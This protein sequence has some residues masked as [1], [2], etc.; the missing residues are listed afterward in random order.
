[1]KIRAAR[2]TVRPEPQALEDRWVPSTLTVLNNLDS[3]PGSLR[4]ENT[5]AHPDDTIIFAPSL[6]RQTV[7]PDRVHTSNTVPS[8]ITGKPIAE[9]Q[10]E[11]H[12]LDRDARRDGPDLGRS[13]AGRRPCEPRP[14]FFLADMRGWPHVAG[15]SPT[16]GERGSCERPGHRL[17]E[18]GAG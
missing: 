13:G 6:N 16:P 7:N 18:H 15:Q 1:R 3:G 8:P 2:P 11:Q 12:R 14:C 10:I 9:Q 17:G 4:A 5:A